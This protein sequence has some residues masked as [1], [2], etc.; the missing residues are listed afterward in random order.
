MSKISRYILYCFAVIFLVGGTF[1]IMKG[2]FPEFTW[3]SFRCLIGGGS[4]F[5]P[6][7]TPFY[8]RAYGIGMGNPGQPCKKYY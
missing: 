7:D 4:T 5:S 6:S 1:G 2:L 3:L 8:V